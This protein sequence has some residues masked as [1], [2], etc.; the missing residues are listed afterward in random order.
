[1]KILA[2]EKQLREDENVIWWPFSLFIKIKRSEVARF[3]A[4]ALAICLL[5]SSY[6]IVKVIR[7]SKFLDDFG[8]YY[9]LFSYYF[10]AVITLVTVFAYNTLIEKCDRE[11]LINRVFFVV[12]IVF[13]V[14][15]VLN[16]IQ[17]YPKMLTIAVY[18]VVCVYILILTSLIWSLIH[19]VFRPEEAKR[20]Y[21][22]ILL[23]AQGGVFFGGKS[24]KYLISTH[25][26][27][28]MDLI[29]VSLAF[30][31]LTYFAV[32]L[33]SHFR[34]RKSTKAQS[35]STGSFADLAKLLKHPYARLIGLLVIFSTFGVSMVDWQVNKLLKTAIAS[36]DE[37]SAFMGEWFGNMALL[38]IFCLLIVGKV[39]SWLGPAAALTG[40]PLVV[41]LSSVAIIGGA[42][43]H[44]LAFFWILCMSMNYTFYNAGK[45]NLYVPTDK[46][47]RYK[48]K[49]LNDVAGYRFGDASA[50]SAILLYIHLISATWTAGVA[51]AS[52]ILGI[53]WFPAIYYARGM[54]KSAVK[55]MDER[56]GK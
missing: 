3:S 47:F 7:S 18:F 39:I 49:A 22:L 48:F 20:I 37:R 34:V 44:V 5:M 11:K 40:L 16:R 53:A 2:E 50:A 51:A 9:L 32:Q 15:W 12:G 38:N 55:V 36:V 17:F 45:E 31:L 52:F 14:I 24:S 26:V 54:Y 41:I 13:T 21:G 33:L 10:N 8:P 42:P 19:D 29:P 28:T 30:L 46:E 25:N 35:K 6:Y 27:K 56:E 4:A 1:M 23:A 43:L